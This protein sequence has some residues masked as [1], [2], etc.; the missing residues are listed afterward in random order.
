MAQII[1]EVIL[2]ALACW[3][4]K[5]IYGVSGDAILPFMDALGKQKEINFYS[6]ATEAGA[7][8]MACGEVRVSGKPGV[9]LATEGP[10]SLNLLNGVADAYRDSVPMLIITGQVETSKINTNV[11][12]YVNQQQLFA[13]VTGFTTLLTRPESAIGVFKLAMEK[14]LGDSTPCH[15]SIPKDIFLS[16][17]HET[18]I[19]ALGHPRPSGIMGN[20]KTTAK[21]IGNCRRPIMIVGRAA[22]PFKDQVLELANLIGAAIIPAQGARGIYPG[23]EGRILAGMGE[24]HIPPIVN[25]T[26]CILLIGD[27]PYEHKYV[28]TE[29]KVIQIDVRPWNIANH[30]SP[31]ALTGDITLILS[32]LIKELSNF[33]PASGWQE[34][35]KQCHEQYIEMIRG[36]AF[37]KDKPI[38]PRQVISLINDTLPEDALIIIDT[39]EF[40]HWFDRGFIARQQPVIISD[41][42][43]C[44][45]CGLP[46]G[47]GAQVAFP[48][49]KIVVLTGNGDFIMTMQELL[50]AVR[51]GLPVVVIIFN[52]GIYALEQHKMQ[53]NGLAPFGT[54]VASLDFVK[55]AEACGAGGIKVEEPERLAE[56]LKKA[57]V[58]DKPTV[59]EIV[60]NQDK[61]VFI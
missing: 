5:N 1:A 31:V 37:L 2:Q 30:L 33:T 13:S 59:I 45:G 19:P 49:K 3:G 35:I 21:L 38:S 20:L 14:A 25:K 34:E 15:I 39:G 17:A 52:N 60:V 50:T 58:L 56:V 11:K 46:Y 47:L 54:T 27:S 48:K 24:A 43:R 53:K 40:M 22:I 12:Q 57:M 6:T 41:Y 8:F 32:S 51:Y 10:G 61:P 9:C 4:V 7:A 28:P 44:M 16:P 26:D 55:L 42:W 29:V 18:D 36:E 23:S